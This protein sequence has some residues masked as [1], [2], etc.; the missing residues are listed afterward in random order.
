M[1]DNMPEKLY[2]RPEVNNTGIYPACDNPDIQGQTEYI[3]AD[4]TAPLPEDRQRALDA[5]DNVQ[6]FCDSVGHRIDQLLDDELQTIRAV[7]TPKQ[8]E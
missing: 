7:L 2:A 3:R 5:L 8:G 4:L 1:S 6:N